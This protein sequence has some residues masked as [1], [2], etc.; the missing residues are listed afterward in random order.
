VLKLTLRGYGNVKCCN[1]NAY[2]MYTVY[3]YIYRRLWVDVIGRSQWLR[4]LRNELS[5][6]AGTLG[7]WIRITLEAL[8]SVCV[9]SLCTVVCVGSGLA[10]G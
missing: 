10:T 7:S 2:F 1:Y 5:P 8:M 9:Y 6:P 3:I 4:G